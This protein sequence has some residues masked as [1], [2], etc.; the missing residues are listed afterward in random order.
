MEENNAPKS[1]LAFFVVILL[2]VTTLAVIVT[3]QNAASIG[4]GFLF[5]HFE[6][7]LAVALL[8]AFALG[9]S[10][11][12]LAMLPSTLRRKQQIAYLEQRVG[13]LDI[14]STRQ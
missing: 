12:L 10:T 8:I 2:M 6:S 5:W 7:P 11:G 9:L 4:V 3:L 1:R 13:G 14:N